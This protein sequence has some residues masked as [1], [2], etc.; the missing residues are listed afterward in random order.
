M[1]YQHH[2]ATLLVRLEDAANVQIP[3]ED[4]SMLIRVWRRK[5]NSPECCQIAGEPK[6]TDL[7]SFL[8]KYRDLIFIQDGKFHKEF[9]E[10]DSNR[11]FLA[12]TDGEERHTMVG[13]PIHMVYFYCPGN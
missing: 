5:G 9:N 11:F 6:I 10:L 4:K 7:S 1:K 13:A 12:F 2:E 8:G 3:E